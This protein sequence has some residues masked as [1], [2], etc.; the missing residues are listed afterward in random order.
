MVIEKIDYGQL[1]C[2]S[3]TL[4]NL[5][6]FINMT[7]DRTDYDVFIMHIYARL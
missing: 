2:L 6:F 4:W 1:C 3:I 7:Y 5:F